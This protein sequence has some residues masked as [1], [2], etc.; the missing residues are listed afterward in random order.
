MT[1]S[2]ICVDASLVVKLVVEEE[3][4]PAVRALWRKKLFNT[5]FAIISRF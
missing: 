1:N 5:Y 2:W 3:Y 4:S